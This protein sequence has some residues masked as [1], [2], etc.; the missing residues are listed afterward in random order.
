MN[1]SG[2]GVPHI[3]PRSSADWQ[4]GHHAPDRRKDDKDPE[5]APEAGSPRSPPA[6]GTGQ[7]VD[8]VV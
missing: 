1:E 4:G 5:A 2:L 7:I 8:R 6:P 3:L